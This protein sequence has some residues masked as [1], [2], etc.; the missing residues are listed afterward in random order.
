MPNPKCDRNTGLYKRLVANTAEPCN[1]QAC[2][3]WTGR[4]RRGYPQVNLRIDGKHRTLKAH[5]AMLVLTELEGETE[6]FG[7]LYDMYS[8]ARMDADHLCFANPVCINPDHLQWLGNSEHARKTRLE[9]H[10][11]AAQFAA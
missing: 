2:W 9:R 7:A 8:A 3:T 5:R 6:L 1:D 4:I 10:P 11:D